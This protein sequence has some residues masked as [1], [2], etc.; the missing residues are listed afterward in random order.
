VRERKER[1][2]QHCAPL[3]FADSHLENRFI[4]FFVAGDPA[5]C[6]FGAIQS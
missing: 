2:E 4:V 3:K 1:A 6:Q 5:S